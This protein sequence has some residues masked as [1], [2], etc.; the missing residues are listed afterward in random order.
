MKRLLFTLLLALVSVPAAFA[1]YDFQI[2]ACTVHSVSVSDDR[3]ILVVSGDCRFILEKSDWVNST[4]NYGRVIIRNSHDPRTL[5]A[6][7]TSW[8]EYQKLARSFEGK[9]TDL[10]CVSDQL[11]I[12]QGR[13]VSISCDTAFFLK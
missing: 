13:I 3:I 11:I 6:G 8:E 7:V 9:K 12:E 1:K 10:A 4:V 2:A 5:P